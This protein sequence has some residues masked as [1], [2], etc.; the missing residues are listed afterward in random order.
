MTIPQSER[1]MSETT[2]CPHCG[3]MA[4]PDS[5]C[6]KCRTLV[7]APATD[8]NAMPE[9]VRQEIVDAHEAVAHTSRLHYVSERTTI[10]LADDRE[11]LLARVEDLE[12]RYRMLRQDYSDMRRVNA[13]R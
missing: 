6:T 1:S 12:R 10:W 2:T 5:V 13:S 4:R 8:T 11:R 9:W 3:D 7:P